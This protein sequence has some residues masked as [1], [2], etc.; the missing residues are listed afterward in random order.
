MTDL[1]AITYKNQP[2]LLNQI[3]EAIAK[4]TDLNTLTQYGE[5]SLRIASNNGRF[6]VVKALLDAGADAG[7]LEW[8]KSMY[9]VVYGTPESLENQ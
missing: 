1:I 6:D 5:S 8:G 7:Q 4:G 2:D 9:E 3:K